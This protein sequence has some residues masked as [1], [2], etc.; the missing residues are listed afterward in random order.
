LVDYQNITKTEGSILLLFFW[1]EQK[2]YR[3]P[4]EGVHTVDDLLVLSKLFIVVRIL[5]ISLANQSN[6]IFAHPPG[7]AKL[8]R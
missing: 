7:R 3:S 2:E 8:T 5:A 6:N 1:E 4:N